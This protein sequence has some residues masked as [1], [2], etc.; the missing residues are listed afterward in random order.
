MGSSMCVLK[1]VKELFVFFSSFD[2]ASMQ[3]SISLASYI[4]LMFMR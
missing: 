1:V 3:N 4:Y 2:C